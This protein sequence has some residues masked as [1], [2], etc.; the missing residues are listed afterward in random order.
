[1]RLSVR[2]LAC[3]FF[4]GVALSWKASADE[5]FTPAQR[6]EIVHIMREALKNDPSILRD[7]V[8]ALQAD[9]QKR[10]KAASQ[11]AIAAHES[12]IVSP[13]DPVAG[14]PAGD[15]TIVEFFDIRCPYCRRFEPSLEQLVGQ[16][17]GI[18]IVFKDLPILGAPSVLAAKAMLAAQHQG[19][20]LQLRAALMRDSQPPTEAG[21]RAMAP[22]LGID[23]DRLVRDMDDPA[24]QKRIDANIQLARE[25]G[26]DGTPAMVI[27]KQLVPGEVT[28]AEM[29]GYIA[30]A[31]K[32]D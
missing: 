2:V 19:K 32:A 25:L 18:R 31:R 23:P 28:V 14:N 10:E 17:H 1:M 20:Y 27:G 4:F 5:Q 9:T 8:A 16:D 6:A 13:S 21:I 26:I 15:V 24:I 12:E 30:A 11:E 22:A 7:A 29:E 3:L